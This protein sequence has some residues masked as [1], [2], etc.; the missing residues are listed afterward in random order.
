MVSAP[1][2]YIPT[3][4]CQTT[5]LIILAT[6]LRNSDPRS[7]VT[8]HRLGFAEVS[9]EFIAICYQTIARYAAAIFAVFFRA[10]HPQAGKKIHR[11]T[12][13]WGVGGRY[14]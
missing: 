2:R 1:A 8:A 9:V 14:L 13:L 11:D 10:G 4:R 12:E 7:I 5:W 6:P 3:D